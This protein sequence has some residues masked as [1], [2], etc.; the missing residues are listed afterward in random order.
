ME[1]DNIVNLKYLRLLLLRQKSHVVH[2][3][4]RVQ[5]SY[6]HIFVLVSVNIQRKVKKKKF[7]VTNKSKKLIR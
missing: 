3:K 2:Q 4:L 7:T 6:L 1:H 5:I